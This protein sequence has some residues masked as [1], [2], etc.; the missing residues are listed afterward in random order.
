MERPRLA[1]LL[2]VLAQACHSIEEYRFALWLH[3]RPARLVSEALSI[4]PPRGFLIANT[5]LCLFGLWCWAVPLRRVWPA[6]RPIAWGW[7]AVEG[8]NGIG[9]VL[10]AGLAGGYFPGLATAPLL[11][12]SSANLAFQLRRGMA[13]RAG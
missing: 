2:L 12:A 9:H 3:L 4:D 13:V 5:A 11:L 7:A 1:L 6:A 8:A 10:L